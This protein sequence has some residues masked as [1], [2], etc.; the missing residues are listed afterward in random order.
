[1]HVGA[2]PVETAEGTPGELLRQT[3]F[4]AVVIVRPGVGLVDALHGGPHVHVVAP[5]RFEV[6]A[7]RPEAAL[8]HVARPQVGHLVLG[9]AHQLG[10][11]GA[12]LD[13]RDPGVGVDVKHAV[14]VD[15][16]AGVALGDA[17]AGGR[18]AAPGA[19]DVVGVHGAD[20]AR[21]GGTLERRVGLILHRPVAGV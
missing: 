6:G 9:F 3:L 8:F 20:G 13:V 17:G 19:G 2:A 5:G 10:F 11:G 16:E 21:V 7:A 4:H 14:G 18:S 12:V 1:E 15:D